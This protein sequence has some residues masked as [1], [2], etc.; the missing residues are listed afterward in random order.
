MDFSIL[1]TCFCL[2]FHLRNK[3]Y[4]DLTEFF[5]CSDS[6][7]WI[8]PLDI[9]R[10]S[11]DLSQQAWISFNM[12]LYCDLFLPSSALPSL[13]PSF[14]PPLLLFL[15]FPEYLSSQIWW[16]NLIRAE[17]EAAKVRNRVKEGG[18]VIMN[19]QWPLRADKVEITVFK[20]DRV[21]LKERGVLN[22]VTTLAKAV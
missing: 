11:S 21:N 7:L 16:R 2:I 6:L 1:S 3:K 15:S 9:L 12:F 22:L 14:L 4:K 19:G 17:K 5:L 10:S 13:L 18:R 20:S 8:F